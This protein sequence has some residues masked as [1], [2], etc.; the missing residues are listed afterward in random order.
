M[1]DPLDDIVNHPELKH[2]TVEELSAIVSDIQR[3]YQGKGDVL[4]LL[5]LE[6]AMST[7]LADYQDSDIAQ[8]SARLSSMIESIRKK[9][10]PLNS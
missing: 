9:N 6:V 7:I 2:S 10:R 1:A 3:I 4:K 5:S 8:S